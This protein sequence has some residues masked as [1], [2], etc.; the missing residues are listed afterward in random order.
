MC[1]PCP[2]HSNYDF[3]EMSLSASAFTLSLSLTV[4]GGSLI[5]LHKCRV[6]E[7]RCKLVKYLWFLYFYAECSME[8]IGKEGA[9]AAADSKLAAVNPGIISNFNNTGKL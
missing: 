5:V 3:L 6:R 1:H 7:P 8:S 2:K 4:S 9:D